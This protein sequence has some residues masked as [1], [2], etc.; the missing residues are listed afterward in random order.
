MND[1]IA[2]LM[3]LVVGAGAVVLGGVWLVAHPWVIVAAV[4]AL[5]LWAQTGG[6]PQEKKPDPVKTVSQEYNKR[7][8]KL[9]SAYKEASK[10]VN[11]IVG[12]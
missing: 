9:R 7:E 11:R 2:V 6:E 4:V 5:V 3:L 10:N 8:A 12:K 1:G